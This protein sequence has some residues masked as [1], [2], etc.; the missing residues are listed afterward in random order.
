MN[1]LQLAPLHRAGRLFAGGGQI[2][3]RDSLDFVVDGVRLSERIPGDVASCLGWGK[4]EWEAGVVE[5]LLLKHAADFP[6]DRMRSI[7]ARNA[8]ILDAARSLFSFN[9]TVGRSSGRIS[10]GKTTT[11]TE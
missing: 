10:A 6:G 4:P 9:V 8:A 5:K 3:E 11:K 1:Q 7:S 2:T